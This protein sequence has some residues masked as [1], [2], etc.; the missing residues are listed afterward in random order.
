MLGASGAINIVPRWGADDG[1]AFS[2]INIAR[3]WGADD[4]DAF[5]TI[6]IAPRWGAG[7]RG[8]LLRYEHCTPLG[9]G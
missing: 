9:R 3:R 2:T 8:R 6:N 1:D 5:F 4:G 7:G